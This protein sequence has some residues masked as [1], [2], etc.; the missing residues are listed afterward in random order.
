MAEEKPVPF[1]SHNPPYQSTMVVLETENQTA[2]GD[3]EEAK[4]C[5]IFPGCI[6]KSME[7]A[8]D[9][10]VAIRKRPAVVCAG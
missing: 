10:T 3:G 5:N 1:D 2:A 8:S 4:C 7:G 6:A 9:E